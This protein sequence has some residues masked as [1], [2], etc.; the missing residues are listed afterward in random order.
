MNA[1]RQIYIERNGNLAQLI[2]NRPEKRN[3]LNVA[4]WRAIPEMLAPLREDRHLRAL[5]VRGAGGV[6]SAGADI[7][8][9]DTVY[10]SRQAAIDN[11]LTI[12]A[13]MTAVESFPAPTLAAIEGACVGGGCGL[14]LACDLRIAEGDSRLGITPGKLGLAY[15]VSD[16]RRLVEAVGVS[17]AKQ[18]L[19]TGALI[20][21]EEAKAIGLVDEVCAPGAIEQAVGEIVSALQSASG[22]TA[23]TTKTILRMLASGVTDDTDESRALFGDSF[24]GEDFKEGFQAFMQKRAPR[25]A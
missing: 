12:Q 2:L 15:G 25:F 20:G 14:A 24:D 13:A 6:F 4:M 1:N 10:A 8:E 3:A 5:I 18:I 19:F 21:A 16:T 7:A 17:N 23:R 11:H 22:H 9:F